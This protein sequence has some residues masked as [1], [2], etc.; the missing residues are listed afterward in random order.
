[1]K[2]TEGFKRDKN[3]MHPLNERE[4]KEKKRKEKQSKAAA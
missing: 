3:N 4:Q 1:M 2:K